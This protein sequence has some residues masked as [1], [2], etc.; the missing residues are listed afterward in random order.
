MESLI[1]P[2][3]R[4]DGN[5]IRITMRLIESAPT[6]KR[7][8]LIEKIQSYLINDMK[9]DRQAVHPTGMAVLY[10]NFLQSLYKSQI[11]TLGDVLVSNILMYV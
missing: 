10:N 6:L 4:E 1:D 3:L 11:L 9:L 5:Q 2:Y 7:K 8:E